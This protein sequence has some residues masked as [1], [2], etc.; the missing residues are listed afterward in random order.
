MKR[1]LLAWVISLPA[2]A[3]AAEPPLEVGFGETEITPKLGDKPV[4]MAGFGQ[5]RKAKGVHDPL[6]ARAWVLR[7]GKEKLA[8]VS[9]DLVGFFRPNVLHVRAD[10]PGFSYVLVNSTHN[11]EGPDTLGLWGPTPLQ[12]GV[13]P[14]YLKRV[15]KQIVRAVRQA[16]K[17]CV[18]AKA[19]IGQAPA[20]HLLRDSREPYLE[21]EDLIVLDFADARGKRVGLVVQWNCHPETLGGKNTEISADYV[22][23]LVR[24]LQEK[25]SCPVVYFTGTVGGLMTSLGVEVKSAGGKRLE[26]GTF[27]K[28]ERLGELLSE[29][30]SRAVKGAKPLDLTPWEVRSREVYLPMDNKFYELARRLGVL[31]RDAYLWAGDP[32]RAEKADPAEAKKRIATRTEVGWLRLGQLEVAAIPGEIYPELVLGKVQDPPDPGADFPK[33]PMEPAI[34]AQMRG[35]HRMILGLAND[36]I[37]YIIPRR[38]WDEKPPFCYGR[39]KKQYGEVN[40]LGSQTAPLLCEAFRDLVKGKG[41]SRVTP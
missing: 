6:K 30:A 32:Y 40:S 15:E 5:N 23:S 26:D 37:G 38:Q 2:V 16:E 3:G 10:L 4:F 34:Y 11:H 39:K 33:A 12:S 18:P 8:L 25:Y 9:V 14:A 22:G 27:E 29:V 1:W 24:R 28:T 19:R 7:R 21:H 41:R 36:E 17:A 31:R 13:D 35:P 20:G